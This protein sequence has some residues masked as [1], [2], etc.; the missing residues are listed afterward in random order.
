[1]PFLLNGDRV[2]SS[3]IHGM[4]SPKLRTPNSSRQP[5]PRERQLSLLK[6]NQTYH[7]H[8]LLLV[9]TKCIPLAELEFP[10]LAVKSLRS[11]QLVWG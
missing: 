3:I 11:D 8:P 5:S 2:R 10:P 4:D 6:F 7:H 9:R 1:M